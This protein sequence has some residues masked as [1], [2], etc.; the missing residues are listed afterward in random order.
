MNDI[1]NLDDVIHKDHKHDYVKNTSMDVLKTSIHVIFLGVSI[2][3]SETEGLYE[4][5]NLANPYLHTTSRVYIRMIADMKVFLDKRFSNIYNDFNHEIM[6][7][8]VQNQKNLVYLQD[9][10]RTYDLILNDDR[11]KVL[12]LFIF[13]NLV[14]ID[15]C[16]PLVEHIDNVCNKLDVFRHLIHCI[17]SFVLIIAKRSVIPEHRAVYKGTI[18]Y[19]LIMHCGDECSMIVDNKKFK[20]KSGSSLLTD[21]GNEISIVNDSDV[22]L[23]IL[24]LELVKP[25]EG[26]YG[27]LNEVVIQVASTN[28]IVKHACQAS[29]IK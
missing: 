14:N 19:Y 7:I 1:I 11:C 5:F 12:T 8:I 21:P 3:I 25:I 4:L 10:D 13:D 16:K 26:V 28:H 29:L 27:L 17:T 2:H 22:E 6:K 24:C 15:I 18:H 9:V 20:L 23:I